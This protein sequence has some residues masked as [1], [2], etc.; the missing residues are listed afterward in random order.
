MNKQ[1]QK[2][3]ICENIN[4]LRKKN[5]LSI[6]ELGAKTNIDIGILADINYGIIPD[7]FMLD[8]YFTLCELFNIKPSRLCAKKI[9]F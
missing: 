7:T 2:R 9:L 6:Q 5:N 3:I 8:D 1:E 4:A